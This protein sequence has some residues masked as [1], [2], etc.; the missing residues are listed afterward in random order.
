MW[1]GFSTAIA[2]HG[3]GELLLQV[4]MVSK[5]LRQT[6]MMQFIKDEIQVARSIPKRDE[7]PMEQHTRD[8]LIKKLMGQ[9][10]MTT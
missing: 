1:P 2:K 8:H 3:T 4:N 7:I 5:V 9:V 6:S 10:V